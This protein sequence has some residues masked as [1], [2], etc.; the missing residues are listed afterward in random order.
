MIHSITG[1]HKIKKNLKKKKNIGTPNTVEEVVSHAVVTPTRH[2]HK[3]NNLTVYVTTIYE[4]HDCHHGCKERV[5][6]LLLFLISLIILQP[7]L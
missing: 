1:N 2:R 6:H 5:R 7:I 4:L 3:S